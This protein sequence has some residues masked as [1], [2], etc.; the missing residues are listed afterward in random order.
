MK[1]TKKCNCKVVRDVEKMINTID[2][3]NLSSSKD[4]D[5][6]KR[7]F[8]GWSFK[9]ISYILYYSLIILFI[10]FIIP[11]LIIIFITTVIFRK[12]IKLSQLFEW[13]RKS[14]KKYAEL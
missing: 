11:A 13:L 7:L 6:N 5:L 10:I 9:I 4:Y 1:E 8:N 3:I 14:I 12:K 2:E